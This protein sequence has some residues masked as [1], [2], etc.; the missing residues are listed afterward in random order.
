MLKNVLKGT[1]VG[2]LAKAVNSIGFLFIIPLM[3]QKN[4]IATGKLADDR[5]S[6]GRSLV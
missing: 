6:W 1:D 4:S 3:L 2:L 5:N